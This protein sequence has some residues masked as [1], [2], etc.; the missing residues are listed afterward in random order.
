MLADNSRSPS[1]SLDSV[2]L[3]SQSRIEDS[4]RVI[5]N[6]AEY[7]GELLS[8]YFGESYSEVYPENSMPTSVDLPCDIMNDYDYQPTFD[9]FL[10]PPLPPLNFNDPLESVINEYEEANAKKIKPEPI[11]EEDLEDQK[12]LLEQRSLVSKFSSRV[13]P[14][15]LPRAEQLKQRRGRP[16]RAGSNSKMANYARQYREMKKLQLEESI[17]QVVDLHAEN[18]E[19]RERYTD[20]YNGYKNL[21][22]EVQRLRNLLSGHIDVP[23]KSY[24]ETKK[25]EIF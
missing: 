5:F 22:D 12:P 24:E 7:E 6:C 16:S 21:Q 13:S 14:Y 11:D 2:L 23:S 4:E 18:K 15:T 20:L 19:L 1:E 10:N 17:K 3:S 25:V 9:D 8:K